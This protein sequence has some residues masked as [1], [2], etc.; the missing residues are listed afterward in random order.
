MGLS[1]RAAVAV[2]SLTAIIL[3]T[4]IVRDLQRKIRDERRNLN[5]NYASVLSWLWTTSVLAINPPPPS[6]VKVL[7]YHNDAAR[8]GQNLEERTL[9]F[10]NVKAAQFGKVGFLPVDGLVDAEPL[11]VSNLTV[12]GRARN[13][14]F[15][16]T[17]HDSVSAFDAGHFRPNCGR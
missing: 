14:V 8:T 2:L 10:G 16:V 12:G 7:T 15:V 6:K 4:F 17:E 11:Y 5:E 3:T 1:K 9:T 13:V